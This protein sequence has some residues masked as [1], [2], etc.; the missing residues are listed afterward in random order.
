MVPLDLF[1]FGFDLPSDWEIVRHLLTP[2]SGRLEFCTIDGL[3]ADFAWT[4]TRREPDLRRTLEGVRRKYYKE[5]RNDDAYNTFAGL[6][7]ERIG[8]LDYGYDR[9]GLPGHAG[10]WLK[11]RNLLLQWF[12]PKHDMAFA[13]DVAY[14][15]MRSFREWKGEESHWSLFGLRASL[16]RSFQLTKASVYPA[17][18]TLELETEKKHRVRLHRWGLPDLMTRG[19]SLEN[20]YHLYVMKRFRSIVKKTRPAHFFGWR[21]AE[22]E[23]KRRGQVGFE[24]L[25]GPFWKGVGQIVRPDTEQRLYAAEQYGPRKTNYLPF[26][27]IFSRLVQRR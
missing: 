26:E 21:G 16:P 27:K 13:R 1:D 19:T 11:E 3:V 9:N 10:I 22:L 15:I 18:V 12:F 20:F 2:E 5:A 4:T 17:D 8:E 24:L 14:P 25:Y 23:F 6:K 7:I